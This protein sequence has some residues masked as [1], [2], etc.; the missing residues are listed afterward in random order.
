ML[1]NDK[2]YIIVRSDLTYGQQAAQ[3]LHAKAEFI[4]KYQE[5]ARAWHDE[6]N[7]VCILQIE[8][9]AKLFELLQKSKQLN[10]ECAEFYESDLADSLTAICLA[11]G[12][13]SKKLVQKLK[14]AFK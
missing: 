10:I 4:F 9:E 13:L 8:N 2:L 11:P 14:L 3:A 5:T 12:K 1:Q 7:Y 6:S